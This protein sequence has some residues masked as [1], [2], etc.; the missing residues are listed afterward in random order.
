[1]KVDD[2]YEGFDLDAYLRG[3]LGSV[4]RFGA[5]SI[6]GQSVS[7][8]QYAGW[9]VHYIGH[10]DDQRLGACDGTCKRDT[11]TTG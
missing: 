9:K 8:R 3:F 2:H 5:A 10:R 11:S 1:M 4:V 7:N 6:H